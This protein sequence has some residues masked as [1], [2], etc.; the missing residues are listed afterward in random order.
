MTIFYSFEDGEG[1]GG[2]YFFRNISPWNSWLSN[3]MLFKN[4]MIYKQRV[5]ISP[6][7]DIFLQVFCKKY[8]WK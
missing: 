7:S 2:G 4:V 1:E 6:T 8:W 5:N 3:K